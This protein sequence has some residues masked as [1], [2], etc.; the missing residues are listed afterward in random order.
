MGGQEGGWLNVDPGNAGCRGGR[1]GRR[2]RGSGCRCARGGGRP[3]RCGC[4]CGGFGGS[5][6]GLLDGV[7]VIVG[8]DVGVGVVKGMWSRP[9][10]Y[11]ES[12]PTLP[13]SMAEDSR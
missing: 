13:I 7:C 6:R 4:A 3:G 9:A 10:P 11:I 12:W 5:G 8:V 1:Y 2:G